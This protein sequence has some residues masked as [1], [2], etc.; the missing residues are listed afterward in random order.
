MGWWATGNGDDV[1]GDGPADIMMDAFIDIVSNSTNRGTP[2]LTIKEMLDV[3]VVA[4]RLNPGDIVAEGG[5]VALKRVVAEIEGGAGH[6][7]GSDYPGPDDSFVQSF[8]SAFK[9]ISIEFEDMGMDRKPRVN[10]LL[11]TI[12]FVLGYR[13]ESYASITEATPIK[14]IFAEFDA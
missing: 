10:E 2:I 12:D 14:R 11:A 1:I 4:L 3:I 5:R 13:L 8:F 9:K 6:I 7:R